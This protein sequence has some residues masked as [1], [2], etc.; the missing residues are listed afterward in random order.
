MSLDLGSKGGIPLE[1]IVEESSGDQGSSLGA[2][3][4]SE[5]IDMAKFVKVV[6]GIDGYDSDLSTWAW[7]VISLS[8]ANEPIWQFQNLLLSSPIL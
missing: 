8:K 3:T 5:V 7:D 2:A 4:C 1:Y 6:I